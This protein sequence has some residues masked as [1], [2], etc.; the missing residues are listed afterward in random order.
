MSIEQIPFGI[1][2]CC[3]VV[4]TAFCDF[5]SVKY[6]VCSVV[7]VFDVD[8][9]GFLGMEAGFLEVGILEVGLVDVGVLEVSKV[10]VG[11]LEVAETEAILVEVTFIEVSLI[12]VDS[13]RY[14]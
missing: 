7:G 6:A 14:S 2:V 12:E 1:L 9:A 4:D 13:T 3:E 11:L 10:E 8:I 5:A